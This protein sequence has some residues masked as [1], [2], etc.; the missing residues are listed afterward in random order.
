MGHCIGQAGG[1][2]LPDVRHDEAVPTSSMISPSQHLQSILDQVSPVGVV[3]T[4]LRECH[5]LALAQTVTA[6]IPLP[7]FTNSAMDGYAVRSVDVQ[8][9]PVTLAVSQDVPAGQI[10]AE[11]LR[12][13][14]AMRIMTGAPLPVGADAVVRV[15]WTD[16]GVKEVRVN[17][18]VTPGAEI[19]SAGGDVAVGDELGRV[20]EPIGPADVA[21]FASLGLTSVPTHRRVRVAVVS[22]G[23]ELT[24]PGERLQPG[25]IYDSNSYLMAALMREAGAEVV[26]Q[27]SLTDNAAHARDVLLS[28]AEQVDLIVTMGGISAGAYEVVKDVF[29][30]TV[31]PFNHVN[32]VAV[33][34]QPGKPQG[35][36]TLLGTP[37]ITLP[38]NPVSSLVSFELFVR[39]ALRRLGGYTAIHRPVV[40]LRLEADIP[41]VVDRTRYVLGRIIWAQ[42]AVVPSAKRGS[43]LIAGAGGNDALIEVEPGQQLTAGTLIA[44]R[45]LT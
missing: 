16:G 32:F 23:D 17:R 20:G 18:A 21:L 35:F 4:P 27:L 7:P 45:Y 10:A 44:L 38:G 15:E 8:Q 13:G 40:K 24:P 33:A 36:G 5:G 6:A 1:R 41:A 42:G 19:R 9:A 31:E 29:D 25:R 14:T 30:A 22:T 2:R 43:H 39:P 37:V 11:E 3:H 26:Q 28:L 12:P 34:I